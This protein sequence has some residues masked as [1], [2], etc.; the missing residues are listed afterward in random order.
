MK[1]S[2]SAARFRESLEQARLDEENEE[3]RVLYALG[4]L[5]ADQAEMLR[6]DAQLIVQVLVNLLDNGLKHTPPESSL[7][8]S[9][10]RDGGFVTVSVEDE[11]AGI[12]DEEKGKIFD[13]FYTGSSGVSDGRR[14]LGFGLALCRTIVDAHGGKIWVEDREPHGAAFRFT[15][16]AEEVALNG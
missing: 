3:R 7:R 16:P 12:P 15:L 5:V 2:A 4:V 14:S 11:G 1:L 9:A 10:E 6:A 8:L 13:M